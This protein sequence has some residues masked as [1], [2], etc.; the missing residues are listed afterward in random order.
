MFSWCSRKN[1]SLSGVGILPCIYI[2]SAVFLSIIFIMTTVNISNSEIAIKSESVHFIVFITIELTAMTVFIFKKKTIDEIY[3]AMGRR[4][5]DYENTLDEECY[6]VIANAYKSGRSRKKIFHDMF[7][8]CS[9]STLLTASIV[10][11]LLSYFKGDPDPNDGILRVLPVPLWTP[12]KTKTWYVNLLFFLAEDV[13]AYMTPGIVFGCILFVVCASE[14][15][16]AQLIILGHT[17]KSVVRRAEGLDMPREEALKLCFVHSIKHHQMLLK[18]IKSLEAIIYLPGFVLLFGS[19]I[20]M[21][22]SGFIFVSKEVAF[23]SKVE[24]FLFLLS[25][26]AVIFLICW[27]GEFIQTTSTQIFDMVYSSEWPDNM[28]SMKNFVLIIQLRSIDSIKLNL[29]GFMV[30]SLE[31]FGN[32]CSSAFS[33]F[34]LMLAVN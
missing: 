11:P 2:P 5:Y 27:C 9:M 26:M 33:Y 28:E 3:R 16:G 19:T 1:A 17:L 13:I 7:V 6:D 21:C 30:A 8:G 22:M 24:F 31:T 32:I 18:Y 15:V 4:F 10:R 34:D 14:D 29:G 25:E 23:I 20:L 12:F